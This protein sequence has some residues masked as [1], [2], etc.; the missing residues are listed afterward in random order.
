MSKIPGPDSIAYRFFAGQPLD[1]RYRTDARFFHRGHKLLIPVAVHRWAYLP[2]CL[3]LAV[4]LAVIVG[5]PA[6]GWTYWR[7]PTATLRAVAITGTLAALYAVLRARRA[8][9]TRQDHRTFVAPLHAVLASLLGLPATTRPGEYITVPHTFRTREDTPAR[10]VLPRHFASTHGAREQLTAAVLPKLGLNEDNTDVIYHMVGR[11]VLELRMAPQPPE[12][13]LWGDCGEILA[14]LRPGQVFV[15]LGARGKPYVR[16]FGS[17]EL[18]HGGFSVQTGYG[19]SSS[20]LAWLVQELHNDPG[21]LVTFIDPKHSP[22]P[23]C[24]VGV[25][26]YTLINDPDDVDAMWTGIE[27]FEEEIVRRR[28]VRMADPTAEFPLAY[29]VLDELSEFTDMSGQYWDEIRDKGSKKTPP[30]WRSI[31]R[32]MRMG[33]EYGARVLTFTQRLDNRSTGNFGLRDLLG[34]RGLAGFRRNQWMMLVATT[35]IPK[36]VNRKG[37]WIYDDGEKQVWVQNVYATPEQLR[38]Y[39]MSGRRPVDT[40]RGQTAVSDSLSGQTPMS[41]QWD[42]I[43]LQAGADYLGVPYET[44]RKRRARHPIDGEGT[45]KGRT[46]AWTRDMLDRY[47]EA[48]SLE[49]Q[50]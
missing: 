19:K 1:G 6:A 23:A 32:I 2:G 13:V 18:V 12:I 33:R 42:I 38:D 5:L 24:L 25:P 31:S 21:T 41:V 15:G 17:G 48:L 30:I 20:A 4:R 36:S 7:H 40:P 44:F 50:P 37:R 10:I 16:D 22:L 28:K 11:P 47:A 45:A 9:V 14:G 46:P 34:W 49:V 35:P 26:G 3:R 29:L 43:G 27:R 8:W 39:A